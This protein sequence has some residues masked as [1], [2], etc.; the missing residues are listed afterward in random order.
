MNALIEVNFLD[1]VQFFRFLKGSCHGNQLCGKLV[2]KLPTP[3]TYRSDI[4]NGMGYRYLNELNEDALL[5][6]SDLG[7]DEYRQSL[8]IYVRFHFCFREFLLL[9][10]ISML[11]CCTTV[12]ERRPAGITAVPQYSSCFLNFLTTCSFLR[13]GF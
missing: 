11:S 1:P 4:R 13:V 5:L 8:V 6:L 9:C 2:A 12:C 10:S 3:C 7:I